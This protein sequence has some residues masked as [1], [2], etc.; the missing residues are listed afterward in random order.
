M[1]KEWGHGYITG[2]NDGLRG[3][4]KAVCELQDPDVYA[5]AL[6]VVMMETHTD[7]KMVQKLHEAIMRSKPLAGLYVK[8][9][10]GAAG[11]GMLVDYLPAHSKK[12]AINTLEEMAR[13]PR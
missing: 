4:A 3:A 13:V 9:F 8:G 7:K 6:L 12:T 10:W 2:K 11:S 1:S 5:M